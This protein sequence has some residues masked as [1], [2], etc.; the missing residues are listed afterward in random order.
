VHET[1]CIVLA[2]NAVGVFPNIESGV[3]FAALF[4]HFLAAAFFVIRLL[5]GAFPR[6]DVS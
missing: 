1:E 5:Y 3:Y 6:G 2:L 4:L